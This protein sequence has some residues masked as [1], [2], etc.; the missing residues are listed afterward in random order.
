MQCNGPAEKEE[1]RVDIESIHECLKIIRSQKSN[2][3]GG[4]PFGLF[5]TLH[6]FGFQ[7]ELCIVA[8]YALAGLIS[9]R[10]VSVVY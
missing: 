10:E 1:P 3:C 6:P 8:A 9:A 5:S 4:M 7:E 2:T